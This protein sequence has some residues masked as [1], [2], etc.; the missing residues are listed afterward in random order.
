MLTDTKKRSRWLANLGMEINPDGTPAMGYAYKAIE[1]MHLMHCNEIKAGLNKRDGILHAYRFDFV[2]DYCYSLPCA[3]AIEAFRKFAR[4]PLM[5]VMAGSGWWAKILNEVGIETE[6]IDKCLEDNMYI[7]KKHFDIKYG[8]AI[9]FIGGLTSP[10]DIILSWPPYEGADAYYALCKL[11]I[12][13]RVFYMGEGVGGCTGELCMFRCFEKN[14]KSLCEVMLPQFFGMH[15][16]LEVFEK[17]NN[18]PVDEKD[19]GKGFV[20]RDE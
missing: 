16:Y 7:K 10:R 15:D 17:V 2:K 11:P 5:D 18:C 3:E 19:I 1:K 8:D 6:A 4:P 12:G 14:F 20:W 13:S 9:E